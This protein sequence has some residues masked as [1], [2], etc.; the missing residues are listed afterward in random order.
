M[1]LSDA[2]LSSTIYQP[3]NPEIRSHLDPEYAA[4]HDKYIQY[5]EPDHVRPW[6][7]VSTRTR[8]PFPPGGSAPVPVKDVK[9]IELEHCTVRVF[10]PTGERP[11][12]GW[13]V[14]VWYHGGGWAIGG[15]Q[16]ENDFY[17]SC[18]IVTVGYRLAPEHPYPA[19]VDDSL[20][21]LIWVHSEDGSRELDIDNA[22]IAIGGTSAGGNL[23]LVTCLNASIFPTPI[24]L[25]FQMLIIPVI[26]NT[27]T[28]DTVW[29]SRQH[30]PW[31]SPA[32]M[33]WYRNMYLTAA[34][35]AYNWSAS[36][37]LAP[38]DL[39]SKLPPSWIAVAEQDVLA[40]EALDFA[41]RVSSLGIK[42][43]VKIY[44]G[45]THTILAMNGVLSQGKQLV[46]DAAQVLREAFADN[47]A[48][49]T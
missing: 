36:P 40:P 8:V 49:R 47:S 37:N 24:P 35:D 1:R 33:T 32:R 6:D 46:A 39:L 30:A 43:D 9:D 15:I 3:L 19:A 10:W 48:Q 7:S 34:S 13:P 45:M 28:T 26:D 22:R 18:V 4:F 31:L 21:A 20:E 42:V 16:S 41:D 23:S 11:A 17:T 12:N 44:P 27:A 14:F 29:R 5:V 25:V 2:E 38:P